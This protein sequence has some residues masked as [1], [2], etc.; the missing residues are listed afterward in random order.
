MKV[1]IFNKKKLFFLII[2]FA[3]ILIISLLLIFMP[4]GYPLK[5]ENEISY[6]AEKYSVNAEII[7]G[8]IFA[9]SNFNE[10]A[11]SK[12]GALGL[13]QIMPETAVW[14]SEKMNLTYDEKMIFN[15]LYNLELGTFYLSY[16]NN[17]FENLNAVLAAYNAGEGN[18]CQWL[19]N[20]EYSTDGKDLIT[21]PFRQTN[22]YLEKVNKAINYYK[23]KFSN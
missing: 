19:E 20:R 17:K 9:E 23:E 6:V 22:F 12:K 18:V 4:F 1:L 11:V 14:L 15:P 16:L 5:Y 13:M 3:I 8:V 10:N 21:T 7:A 2:V